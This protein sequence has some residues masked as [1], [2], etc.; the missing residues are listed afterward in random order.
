MRREFLWL[1]D[2]HDER[3]QRR[4]RCVEREGCWKGKSELDLKQLAKQIQDK[5][6]LLENRQ[7]DYKRIFRVE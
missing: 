3:C 6:C 7:F 5:T 1:L 4:H 2:G